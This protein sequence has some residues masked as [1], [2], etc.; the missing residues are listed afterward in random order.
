MREKYVICLLYDTHTENCC[1]YCGYGGN[2]THSG[3]QHKHSRFRAV[4]NRSY[5]VW[6]SI[7][8]RTI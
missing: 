6:A 5:S 2:V 8:E 3:K 7:Q 4:L 1:G